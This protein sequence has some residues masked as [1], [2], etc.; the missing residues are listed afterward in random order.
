MLSDVQ[1]YQINKYLVSKL[2]PTGIIAAVLGFGIGFAVNDWAKS[3][4][5]A[6]ALTQFSSQISNS[7]A[8]IGSAKGKVENAIADIDNDKKKIIKILENVVQASEKVD[9]ILQN[10]KTTRELADSLTKDPTFKEGLLKLTDSKIDQLNNSISVF[11]K[12]IE[13]RVSD[14]EKTSIKYEQDIALQLPAYDGSKLSGGPAGLRTN[15]K[16]IKSDEI[17]QIIR[18]R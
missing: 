2:V 17:W 16:H 8:E 15:V 10:S 14:L 9:A 3:N 1:K 7:A 12:K 11:T 6:N 4:A 5:Y 18:A 13:Q